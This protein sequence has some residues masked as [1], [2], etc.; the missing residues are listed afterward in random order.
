[1]SE[2]IS[3]RDRLPE[4]LVDVIV[5]YRGLD[6]ALARDTGYLRYD[7]LWIFSGTE[8]LVIPNVEFWLP[9]PALPAERIGV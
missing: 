8:M 1:M 5:V 4:P 6:G 9:Y 2:W 7:R 3:I